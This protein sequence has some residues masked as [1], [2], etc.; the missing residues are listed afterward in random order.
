MTVTDLKA[1]LQA[2]LPSNS[3]FGTVTHK[4]LSIPVSQHQ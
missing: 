1:Q 3:H 2:E 4:L